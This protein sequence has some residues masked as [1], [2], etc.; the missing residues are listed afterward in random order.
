M[1]KVTQQ[2][3]VPQRKMNQFWCTYYGEVEKE[4]LRK[5]QKLCGNKTKDEVAPDR[6][7]AQQ[8]HECLYDWE[9]YKD[10]ATRGKYTFTFARM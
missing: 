6:M 5:M 8:A 9:A 2:D 1:A 10:N 3:H 7:N 4:E